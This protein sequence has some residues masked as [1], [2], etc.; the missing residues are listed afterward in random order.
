[1]SVRR[2]PIQVA[3]EYRKSRRDLEGPLQIG[4]V[5]SGGSE[6]ASGNA[7][8]VNDLKREWEAIDLIEGADLSG[9]AI[10]LGRQALHPSAC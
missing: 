4:S 1:M 6:M 8:P 10:H 3:E 2:K 5:K 9:R 7:N